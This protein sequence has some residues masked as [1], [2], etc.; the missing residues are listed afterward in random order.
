MPDSRHKVL[1]DT[2]KKDDVADAQLELLTK[3]IEAKSTS[4]Y[5]YLLYSFT[6]PDPLVDGIR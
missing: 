5:S 6:I 4:K 3:G 2:M 1:R